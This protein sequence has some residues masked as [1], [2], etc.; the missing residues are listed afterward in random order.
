MDM[1]G[2]HG[3][4]LSPGTSDPA[5]DRDRKP[6]TR[7]AEPH[8]HWRTVPKSGNS[9]G[10]LPVLSRSALLRLGPA[11]FIMTLYET[12]TRLGLQTPSSVIFLANMPGVR[13]ITK[14]PAE[15]TR[16][17]KDPEAG[18][19]GAK[20]LTGLGTRWRLRLEAWTGGLAECTASCEAKPPANPHKGNARKVV[21]MRTGLAGGARERPR[22]A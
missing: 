11:G 7:A 13:K 18:P 14:T 10:R 22:S 4:K 3:C 1:R 15:D 8:A 6:Q 19:G 2:V 5:S 20:S 16:H 9:V 17:K 12:H 21:M